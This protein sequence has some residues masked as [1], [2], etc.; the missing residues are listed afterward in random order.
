MR[1]TIRQV[2]QR[3]GVSRTT[4]SNVLLGRH[5]LVTP[6]K[7]DSVLLAV[8]ELNYVPVRSAL[9]NRH[10][11]TWAIA[12]PMNDPGKMSWIINTGTYQ[13]MC[14]A[15]MR[16][17]Y[18]VL[19][20]LRPDPDWATDRC[21]VQFLDHRSDGI[22][23]ASPL[24]RESQSTFET[25]VEQQIPAVACY[26]RDV[27]DGM[28]WVSPDNKSAMFQAVSHLVEQGHNKIAHLTENGQVLFDTLERRRYFAEAVQHHGLYQC[29]DWIVHARF[30]QITPSLIE[31]I[32]DLGATAVVC[33]NDL[34]ALNLWTALESHGLRV[35]DDLSIIGVDGVEAAAR[36]LTS[37][38][39]SFAEVGRKAVDALVAQLQGEPAA[40]CCHL[41]PMQLQARHSVRTI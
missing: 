29:A 32:R 27:P 20:M 9:Q 12:V 24:L 14:D 13:G 1:S 7:R 19:M 34:L 31:Q 30:Y 26:R 28:A 38:E 33:H 37:V 22:V 10:V 39:F 16:H 11:P 21:E 35:P 23:F 6:T 15:A 8:K 5:E 18:D 4:V 36:G 2:A 41:V 40:Q 25:L 17:G 3:A